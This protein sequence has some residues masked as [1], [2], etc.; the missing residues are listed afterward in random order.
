MSEFWLDETASEVIMKA[1][2]EM[3]EKASARLM[4]LWV[5]A[6]AAA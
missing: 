1:I 4:S 2:C 5:Q 3:V 6:M